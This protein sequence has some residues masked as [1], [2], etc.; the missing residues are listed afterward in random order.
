MELHLVHTNA[1]YVLFRR[2]SCGDI[3]LFYDPIGGLPV[4]EMLDEDEFW[5][6]AMFPVPREKVVILR[7]MILRRETSE[8][9]LQELGYGDTASR[10]HKDVTGIA[11]QQDESTS[12]VTLSD[13]IANDLIFP[14]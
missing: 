12:F 13:A 10:I 7:E 3:R 8:R 6:R 9:I 1:D 11:E 5:K 14:D 2:A 4:G